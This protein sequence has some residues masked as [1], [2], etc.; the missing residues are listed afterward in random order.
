MTTRIGPLRAKL[1]ALLL[2]MFATSFANATSFKK[3]ATIVDLVGQ[4]ELIIHG[5][6]KNVTDGIDDR[7]IPYTE[8][9]IRVSEAIK[10][11]IGP[12]YT[13]RQFGLLKPRMMAD[14]RMNLM[15]TPAA[16]STYTKGEETVLFLYKTASWTGLKTTTALGQGKF[17]V[18][19]GN[20]SNQINNAGLF[21]GV[22]ID[23]SLLGDTEK[24]VMATKKGPMNAQGFV[25]LVKQA[26]N[27][28]WIEKGKMKNAK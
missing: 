11:Q 2:I 14:G 28:K 9:T 20:A 19:L 18:N 27:G 12:E 1:W 21:E 26:V 6:V 7:G 15:V 8:V 16:W 24:R 5:T 10:G 23:S 22:Q 3:Q 25:S 13:F 17:S 4:S